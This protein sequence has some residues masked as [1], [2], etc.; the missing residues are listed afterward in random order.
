MANSEITHKTGRIG[1]RAVSI[2]FEKEGYSCEKID[3]DYGED[4]FVYGEE[5]TIIEPFKVFIQVKSKESSE[6][7][8]SDRTVYD[9]SNRTLKNWIVANEMAIVVRYFIQDE[10]AYYCIP[11]EKFN[12]WEIN[13]KGTNVPIKFEKELTPNAIEEIMWKARIRYYDR[14]VRVT[15]PNEFEKSKDVVEYKLFILEFLARIGLVY[16]NQ[17]HENDISK[18]LILSNEFDFQD[19]EDMPAVNKA[20]YAAALIYILG[21]LEEYTNLKLGFKPLFLDSCA[22][23]I[24]QLIPNTGKIKEYEKIQDSL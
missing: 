21:K 2:M 17:I 12:Y 16:N 5:N 13:V 3:V 10:K 19:S 23:V 22:V 4:L 14:L 6:K 18:I 11:E 9:I 15:M 7:K 20:I 8:E 24:L 1:E